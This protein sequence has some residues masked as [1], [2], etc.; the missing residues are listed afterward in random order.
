M[1]SSRQMSTQDHLR[2][3]CNRRQSAGAS[4]TLFPTPRGVD[5]VAISPVVGAGDKMCLKPKFD[6]DIVSHSENCCDLPDTAFLAIKGPTSKVGHSSLILETSSLKEEPTMD[7]LNGSDKDWA[8]EFG[9]IKANSLESIQDCHVA[10]KLIATVRKHRSF[11]KTPSKLNVESVHTRNI[12]DL[13]IIT[14]A[15]QDL[16]IPQK[17]ASGD[18]VEV[19]YVFEEKTYKTQMEKVAEQMEFMYEMASAVEKLFAR[20]LILI[21]GFVKPIEAVVEGLRLELSTIKETLGNRNFAKTDVPAVMWKAVESSFDMINALEKD[22]SIVLK[23][24]M[25]LRS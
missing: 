22:Y 7:L 13:E 4:C 11:G 1:S 10:N 16:C 21:G 9:K 18:P 24:R 20:E 23:L 12:E 6:C 19:E 5:R 8:S 3:L 15:L 25:K 17:D 14:N 2:A